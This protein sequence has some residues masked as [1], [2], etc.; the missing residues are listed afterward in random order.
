MIARAMPAGVAPVRRWLSHA[1]EPHILYPAIAV[2]VLGLVWGTTL[3]LMQGER[4][5]AQRSTAASA[6]DQ[7]H[8]YEAQVLR[9]LQ[10]IDRTLRFVKYAYER[11]GDANV[12]AELK[13]NSLLPPDLLF[14]VAITDGNGAVVAATRNANVPA[15]SGQPLSGARY[16]PDGLW[17]HAPRVDPASGKWR[18][19]FSRILRAA[20]GRFAGVVSVSVE[21]M[22]F[23]SGYEHAEMGAHGV[24]AVIGIDGVVLARRTGEVV[25]FGESMD[26]AS[27]RLDTGEGD[28]AATLATHAWDGVRRYAV[29]HQLAGFPVA[30]LVGLSEE[31]G[32]APSRKASR[33]YLWWASG[34]SVLA[35]L[36]LAALGGMSRQ[37]AFGRRRAAE[38]LVAHGAHVEH[39]AYHDAL[40]GLANRSLF[41]NLLGQG[42]ALAH[43]HGRRLA[44]IFIDL[45]GFKNVNDT[46]GHEVGDHLLRAVA[47]RL[48]G[49]VRESDTVARLGG[50]EFVVLLPELREETDVA[51]VAAKIVVAIGQPFVL[52]GQECRVTASAG[53]AVYPKD[54]VDEQALMK[55]ADVAMYQAKAD[56]KNN[57]RF[58]SEQLN[59]AAAER[60]ALED[61]L[62][63][64]VARGE[65]ELHYQARRDTG[66]GRITAVEA[67]L[68]WHRPGVGIVAPL[69]FIAT[70]EEAGLIV[71]IGKWSLTAACLQGVAWR[72]AGL[73]RLVVAVNLAP[74]QFQDAN[75]LRDLAQVL[76]ETG[77]DAELLEL[78]IPMALLR[79]VEATLRIMEGLKALG[80]RIAID[81]FGAGYLSL[82]TLRRFPLDTIKIDRSF[83]NE[84][85]TAPGELALTR[86]VI[87]MGRTLSVNVVAQGVESREQAEFVRGSACGEFQ[88]FYMD[89]PG[90]AGTITGLLRNQAAAL[91]GDVVA[92][93]RAG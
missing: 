86:A 38:E 78:E 92:A 50:D 65:F 48:A 46:S 4:D 2:V 31:E 27:L 54:G 63:V 79:D 51:A 1:T 21:A 88:G 30:V 47:T 12:L 71:P 57:F 67:L 66:S 83:I 36:V 40:T 7:G 93:G 73:P 35:L 72:E 34:A 55:G 64:A 59:A 82:A 16:S 87:A 52:G 49:C 58:Y 5:A 29:A 3:R 74:R 28:Y 80:V 44:V 60:L 15:A 76:A 91:G 25:A 24:I 39:V 81:D 84:V 6:H 42:I 62:R 53:I 85:G 26:F 9:V 75:L 14:V 22:H 32:L 17:I 37:I 20:D 41:G 23:V 8:V 61:G 69:Q 68:R 43:R 45:D 70:A 19:E 18:L 89:T 77:M 13:A 11:Q 10:E 33:G 90:P 56:G